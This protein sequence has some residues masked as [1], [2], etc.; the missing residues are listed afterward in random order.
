MTDPETHID[1]LNA[2]VEEIRQNHNKIID[3]FSKVYMSGLYAN[4]V[5][6]DPLRITL[7]KTE[8]HEISPGKIGQTFWFEYR[9]EKEDFVVEEIL[10]LIAIT[11]DLNNKTFTSDY[12]KEKLLMILRGEPISIHKNLEPILEDLK[13]RY[14]NNE[15]LFDDMKIDQNFTSWNFYD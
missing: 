7:C 8:L 12:I 10:K 15:K 5:K 3:D 13:A 9:G 14:R 6:V 11:K 1:K 4:G 2:I